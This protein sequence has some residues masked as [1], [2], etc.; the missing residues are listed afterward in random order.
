MYD[1]L[2]PPTNK[3]LPEREVVVIVVVVVV[4]L[5]VVVVVVAFVV[6]FVVVIVVFIVV[7]IVVVLIRGINYYLP[8]SKSIIDE[9]TLLLSTFVATKKHRTQT[10]VRACTHK[11]SPIPSLEI[12]IATSGSSPY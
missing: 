5:V 10:H 6:A 1:E 9:R 7:V 4:V 2:E 11:H 8:I 12:I 3:V